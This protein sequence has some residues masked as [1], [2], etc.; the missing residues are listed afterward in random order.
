MTEAL[1][2]RVKFPTSPQLVE[3]GRDGAVDEET[4]VDEECPTVREAVVVPLASCTP[5]VT[6]VGAADWVMICFEASE[7]WD[8]VLGGLATGK[9]G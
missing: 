2:L 5:S 9:D 7:V 6:V 8:D 1:T 3:V 4:F